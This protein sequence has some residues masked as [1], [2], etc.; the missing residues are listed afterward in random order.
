MQYNFHSKDKKNRIDQIGKDD[1]NRDETLQNLTMHH[2]I[3]SVIRPAA[4]A[5][6]SINHMKLDWNDILWRTIPSETNTPCVA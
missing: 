2:F 1:E 6:K 4:S 3:H 5:R